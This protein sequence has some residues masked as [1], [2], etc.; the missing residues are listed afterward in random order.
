[1]L[2]R[3]RLKVLVLKTRMVEKT[4][5]GSNPS[6][7]ALLSW[8]LTARASGS[9]CYCPRPN[10]TSALAENNGGSQ[11]SWGCLLDIVCGDVHRVVGRKPATLKAY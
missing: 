3:V 4:I 1:M 8:N 11:Q 9:K 10:K 5:G 2:G 7:S 6:A